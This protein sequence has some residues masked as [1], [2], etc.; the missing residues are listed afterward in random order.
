MLSEG[1]S[2]IQYHPSSG[3][4]FDKNPLEKNSRRGPIRTEERRGLAPVFQRRFESCALLHPS[5]DTPRNVQELRLVPCVTLDMSSF[6]CPLLWRRHCETQTI[7]LSLSR[8]EIWTA[9][10]AIGAP[11]Q[12]FIEHTP[13][14]AIF[15]RDFTK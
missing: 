12:F 8:P 6:P 1:S 4:K 15:G 11:V 2:Q 5:A 3:L 10:A 9:I 13:W 7:D 14:I